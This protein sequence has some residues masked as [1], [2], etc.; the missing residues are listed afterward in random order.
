M[1]HGFAEAVLQEALEIELAERKIPFLSQVEIAVQYKGKQLKKFYIADLL[2]YG[3]IIV[4]IKPISRLTPADD[5]QI[6]NYLRATGMKVGLLVN[7]GSTD[8]LEWR[9]FIL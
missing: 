5:A 7:F 8:K 4:E 2:C 1:G 6:I 3:K 9:R